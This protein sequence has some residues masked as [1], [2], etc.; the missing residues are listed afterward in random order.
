[1]PQL[2]Y[3]LIAESISVDQSTNRVSLFN[4]LEEIQCA[5]LPAGTPAIPGR[6]GIPQ[7]VAVSSWNLSPEDQGREFQ[8]SLS[9]GLG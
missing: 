4:V 5:P 3:F 9:G 8:V 7:L 1:M 6:T 2:E